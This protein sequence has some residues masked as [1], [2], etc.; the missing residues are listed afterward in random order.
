MK[1][2][3]IWSKQTTVKVLSDAAY[4]NDFRM[5]CE[6][7]IE[8]A[9]NEYES[10][11]IIITP[12]SDVNSYDL[13][14]DHLHTDKTH[15]YIYK[16]N[17]IVYNQKYIEIKKSSNGTE[18]S[19]FC[20]GFYPD[21][22]LPF[23]KAKEYGENRISA[24]RNQ[25]IWLTLKV[26]ESQPAGL[27]TG[28]FTLIADGKS[29]DIPVSVTIWDFEIPKEV[30][31]Q[32]DFGIHP[33]F[34]KLGENDYFPDMVKKYAEKLIDFRLSPSLL[35]CC[36]N[37]FHSGEDFAND[38]R[39]FCLDG[40]PYLSSIVIRTE[41]HPVTG[42][43]RDS[44]K[45]YA[46]ALMAAAVEDNVNYLERAIVFCWFI[47]E[48]QC[49]DTWDEANLTS[50][51]F[52][53]FKAEIADEFF[54]SGEK[55][56]FRKQVCDAM[57]KVPN[58]VTIHK[59]PRITEVKNYCVCVQDVKTEQQ[60]AQYDFKNNTWWYSC[61]A[62][63]MSPAYV[64]D[65]NILEMRLMPWMSRDYGF[66]GILYWQSA[67]H[68][69]WKFCME[70]HINH[71]TLID[72]YK[73]AW[74]LSAGNGDGFLLYPGAPYGIYGPVESIRLHALRDGM[75]EYEYLYLFEELCEKTGTSAK[76]F[77][78]GLY[79]RLYKDLSVSAD[80]NEFET[81][82][83]ELAEKIVELKNEL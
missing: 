48:P 56:P 55:T 82:R 6:V 3:S 76:E 31:L 21:A 46:R 12:E 70:S 19:G 22:L 71:E 36:Y 52:E 75:E 53:L 32:S 39:H 23:E 15:N 54:E 35:K 16:D 9:R 59:D 68:C 80:A 5:P 62:P 41:P 49:N 2:L 33:Q 47:D 77:L 38:V 7:R 30:H 44:F 57:K 11:Q 25:G 67:L 78:S 34:I 40:K 8:A 24:R 81:V 45:K 37:K 66:G 26:P 17:W 69:E 50:K 27:Y 28:S 58:L 10:A 74:R 83:R 42:F 63:E 65:R 29:Y 4:G 20:K 51:N 73:T 18:E 72:C 79:G 61:G 43:D 64:I 1:S 14:L 60:R 13:K